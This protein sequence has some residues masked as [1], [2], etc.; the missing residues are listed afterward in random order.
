MKRLIFRDQLW[1]WIINNG[2]GMSAFRGPE[3]LPGS[4]AMQPARGRGRNGRGGTAGIV[5]IEGFEDELDC[6][7][8]VGVGAEVDCEAE[9]DGGLKSS[10][11][12]HARNAPV[13]P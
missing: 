4:R 6:D 2:T 3:A 7:V 11:G 12:A 13:A 9:P 1:L 10:G 8:G 5:G